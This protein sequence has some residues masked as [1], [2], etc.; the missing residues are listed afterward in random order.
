MYYPVPW[1]TLHTD[2]AKLAQKIK[3]SGEEFDCIVTVARGGLALSHMLADFLRLPVTSFTVT[4]Y[5]SM[6]KAS[7]PEVSL[8]VAPEIAG[9]R[10]L[11]F[12]D[13]ADTGDTLEYGVSYLKSK[14][15]SRVQTASLYLKATSRITPDYFCNKVQGWVIFPF[16][17]EETLTVYKELQDIDPIKAEALWENILLLELP[18]DLLKI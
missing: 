13:I 4:T 9:K 5:K 3:S 10:V 16:E 6:Q 11:L 2:V 8:S 17:I 1:N 14:S 18:K 15:V 7:R 12:D